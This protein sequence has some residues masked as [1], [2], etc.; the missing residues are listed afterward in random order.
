MR[1]SPNWVTN[2]SKRKVFDS[3]FLFLSFIELIVSVLFIKKHTSTP[4]IQK[5]KLTIS[6]SVK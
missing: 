6:Q 1:E 4:I 5:H 3:S 2:V